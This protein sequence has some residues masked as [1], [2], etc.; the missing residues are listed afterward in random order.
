[1]A[2]DTERTED[3]RRSAI[4]DAAVKV[5]SE[6]GFAGT[7]MANIAEAAGMSRPALYLSFQNK[8]D[9]FASAFAALI[10]S[11]VDRALAAL[12]A[13][14]ST[15]QQLT[16]FLQRF[17]GDL[18]ERMAASPHADEL[19]DAKYQHAAD[20]SSRGTA[21][22]RTGLA[23]Y[24]RRLGAPKARSAEWIDLLELS[25]KGFKVDGPSVAVYRRRLSTLARSV[26]ADIDAVTRTP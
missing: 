7:S 14:G 2:A 19:L 22:L 23:A 26:A 15:E 24:L 18:W 10:E 9:I 5:F 6:R 25:P 11:S 3:R 17:D 8:Q 4:H 13:P 16:G 21:R 12:A 20:A 1:V